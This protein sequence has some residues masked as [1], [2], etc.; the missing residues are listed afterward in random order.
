MA[1]IHGSCYQKFS[2][3]QG[4]EPADHLVGPALDGI[5]VEE[6]QEVKS[7]SIENQVVATR[8][9]GGKGGDVVD[10]DVV[11]HKEWVIGRAT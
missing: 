6:V 9:L 3:W 11:G 2:P 4:V 10:D 7:S 8:L 5:V 1:A